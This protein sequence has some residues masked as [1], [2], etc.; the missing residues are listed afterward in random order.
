MVAR[1]QKKSFPGVFWNFDNASVIWSLKSVDARVHIFLILCN[2]SH[3]AYKE[4]AW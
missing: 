1:G 2:S 4:E 3:N